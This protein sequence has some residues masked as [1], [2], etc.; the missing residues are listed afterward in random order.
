M[1][2][3]QVGLHPHLVAQLDRVIFVAVHIGHGIADDLAVLPA[4]TVASGE[5]DD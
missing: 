2:R 3:A 5:G 4:A 1:L